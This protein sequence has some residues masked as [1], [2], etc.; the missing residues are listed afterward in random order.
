MP[1]S[2]PLNLKNSLRLAWMPL[3]GLFPAL[4]TL[5]VTGVMIAGGTPA[6]DFALPVTAMCGLS[7]AISLIMGLFIGVT[8]LFEIR[9]IRATQASAWVTWP[10]YQS[11]ESW[12]A[13]VEEE[14]RHAL[15]TTGFT[16]GP[17]ITLG[18]ILI[19]V[20]GLTEFVIL[21]S[22]A[23]SRSPRPSAFRSP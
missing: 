16:F 19:I 17:L 10:Q 5:T 11:E 7:L 3:I 13:A 6:S 9:G 12:R 2:A 8:I 22:T 1:S 18:V 14:Y 20:V 21:P 4:L 23:A 15:K